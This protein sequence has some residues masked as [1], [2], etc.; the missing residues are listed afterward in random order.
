MLGVSCREFSRLDDCAT[1]DHWRQSH[2][3]PATRFLNRLCAIDIPSTGERPTPGPLPELPSE[4]LAKALGDPQ[5]MDFVARPRWNG[6]CHETGPYS[7]C[8]DAPLLAV[9]SRRGA[10]TPRYTARLL[11]L[12]H[13]LEEIEA[14]YRLPATAVGAEGGLA[15]VEAARGRL[16]HWIR[17][18]GERVAQYRILAPTEWNFHPQGI[19]AQLMSLI[20]PGPAQTVLCQARLVIAAIDP[21]IGYDLEMADMP[22][23]GPAHA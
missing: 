21:C 14:L 22:H 12:I 16:A 13:T 19:A 3:T 8:H 1:F 18:D 10:L 9:L 4:S 5:A 2:D 11:E 20:P 15:C 23:S 7:R 17:L 6:L